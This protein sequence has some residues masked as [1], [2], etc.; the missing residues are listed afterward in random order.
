MPAKRNINA[1][2]AVLWASAF[3]LAA[4]VITQAGNLPVN[5]AY[6]DM[7]VEADGYTLI[8]VDSGRGEDADPNELLYVID[9]RSEALLVYEVED[10]R[11]RLVTLR[12]VA[13]LPV[14]FNNA[15]R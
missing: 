1:A 13:N 5:P 15:R 7:A 10:A 4:L 11:Q 6:A 2:A 14:W 3:L 12:A 9:S 8:T